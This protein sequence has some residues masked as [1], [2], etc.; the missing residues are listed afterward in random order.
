MDLESSLL[1]RS[2]AD[3]SNLLS[4]NP[5]KALYI[6]IILQIF[7]Q[8]TGICAI[9]FYSSQLFGS[10][11][12]PYNISVGNRVT[13]LI[14]ATNF[15]SAA[16]ALP[17]VDKL[18]RKPMLVIGFFIMSAAIILVGVFKVQDNHLFASILILVFIIAY[19]FSAGPVLWIY[20]PEVLNTAGLS[21][22]SSATWIFIII[23]SLTTPILQKAANEWVF[24]I[25]GICNF[26][27]AVFQWIFLIES[28][29]RSRFEMQEKYL[30]RGTPLVYRQSPWLLILQLITYKWIT[31]TLYLNL[32]KPDSS[33]WQL[34]KKSS[35]RMALSISS[36]KS[37]ILL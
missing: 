15:V 17:F 11:D 26:C 12:D 20:I 34:T 27:G 25:F 28:K 30:G 29:G 2:L 3:S 10:H 13:V 7:K 8:L 24:F 23:I 5:R 9:Y 18:G 33:L 21:L 1:N 19:E 6:C 16:I 4:I 35:N 14:G 36:L 22:A 37:V 32:V 31:F